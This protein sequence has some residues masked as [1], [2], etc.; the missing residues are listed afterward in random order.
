MTLRGPIFLNPL[1]H[2][3]I[4]SPATNWLLPPHAQPAFLRGPRGRPQLPPPRLRLPLSPPPTAP[5]PS[6]SLACRDCCLS[7]E[8]GSVITLLCPW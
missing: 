6:P 3:D 1:D 5:E 8:P 7:L 2:T 4:S